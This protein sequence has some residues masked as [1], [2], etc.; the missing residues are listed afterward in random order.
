MA[1]VSRKNFRKKSIK[2]K[3][4]KSK[5][6][7]KRRGNKKRNTIRGGGS[8]TRVLEEKESGVYV[9]VEGKIGSTEGGSTEGKIFI[10]DNKN[11]VNYQIP[12]I[13]LNNKNVKIINGEKVLTLPDKETKI[14]ISEKTYIVDENKNRPKK[15]GT[16]DITW[17][18]LDCFAAEK[19]ILD[20]IIDKNTYCE[21]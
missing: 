8:R 16:V 3:S 1:K 4:R 17:H 18:R 5:G 6:S 2:N 11:K 14:S 20:G 12:I 15:D 13:D 7:I 19:N 9:Y 10:R 21:R